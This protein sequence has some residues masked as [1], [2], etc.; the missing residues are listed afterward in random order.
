MANERGALD[1]VFHALADPTRRAVIGRLGSGP[2][3][4][5]E[6]A[7]PFPMAFPSFL[8]HISVLEKSRLITCHKKGRVRTCTLDRESLVA[9]ERWFGEQQLLWQNRYANLDGLLAEMDEN[10]GS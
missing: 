1:S 3:T 5:R 6:L 2:A 4:V 9:A 7:V 10:N 8:K